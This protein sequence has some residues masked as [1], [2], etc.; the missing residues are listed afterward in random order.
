MEY[1]TVLAD[2]LC[3]KL[4]GIFTPTSAFSFCIVTLS[5]LHFGCGQVR[6]GVGPIGQ[7]TNWTGMSPQQVA[8]LIVTL[9]G[10]NFIGVSYLTSHAYGKNQGQHSAIAE[11]CQAARL[12]MLTIVRVAGVLKP[13][14]WLSQGLNPFGPTWSDHNQ[15]DV[16]KRPV[17]PVGIIYRSSAHSKR[18]KELYKMAHVQL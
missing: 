4:I 10:F 12:K 17:G 1:I 11:S 8:G 16:Q 3:T 6:W 2:G 5:F 7:I 18:G 14:A 15:Q 9:I 13:A